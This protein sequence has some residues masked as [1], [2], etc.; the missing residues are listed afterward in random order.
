LSAPARTRVSPH[1]MTLRAR[2]SRCSLSV[3]VLLTASCGGSREQAKG[4]GDMALPLNMDHEPCDTGSSSAQKID[5]NGDGKPDIIKV[6]VG[7]RE[8]C[9]MVDLNHDGRP[10]SFIYFDE[11]GAIRRTESDFDRDGFIDEIAHY[12]GGVVV[13]KDRETNLDRKLDTWD[14]YQGGKIHQRLRDSDANGKVDQWWTW[15]NPDKPECAVI[16]SD[17]DNDGQPDPNSVVDQCAVGTTGL[18]SAPDAGAAAAAPQVAAVATSGPAQPDAAAP[19]AATG[20]AKKG[21]K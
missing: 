2:T 1:E 12:S 3:L 11:K 7:A 5:T 15:P 8:V 20:T 18:G 14:F 17:H 13:R 19:D 16:A 9:R 21:S 6:M 10:D 4:P